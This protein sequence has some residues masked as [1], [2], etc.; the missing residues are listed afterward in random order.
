MESRLPNAAGAL[1][2]AAGLVYWLLTVLGGLQFAV[3]GVALVLGLGV[4][5]PSHLTLCL[6]GLG[7]VVLGVLCLVLAS[8]VYAL[9]RAV[10]C[11]SGEMPH[12]AEDD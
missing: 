11:I 3:G 5:T 9:S 7:A 10:L 2:R 8:W 6:G 4:W 1:M 12:A